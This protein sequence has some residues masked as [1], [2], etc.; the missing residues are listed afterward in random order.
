MSQL[1]FIDTKRL[2]L[3]ILRP[4]NA[5]LLHAYQ[6]EN[7]AHLGPWEPSKDADFFTLDA[8][9]KRAEQAYRGF[10]GGNSLHF[11]AIDRRAKK[12]VAV[13]N[14]TNIAR[15]PFLA[16]NLGYS[17]AKASQGQGLMRECA[18]AAIDHVF[19][20]QGL[21]RIMANHVPANF[22]SAKLLKSLGF[23]REGYARKYLLI[24]G[25]WEDMVLNS[26]INP[27]DRLPMQN[28]R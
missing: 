17:V 10:L 8:C 24:A 9:R 27:N 7:K 25:K 4:D 6:V 14:F 12:A 11:L 18:E 13:C 28:L 15:G 26:L 20:V 22:R 19:K 2:Y 16:C 5:P 21:H 3:T 23:E 1:P